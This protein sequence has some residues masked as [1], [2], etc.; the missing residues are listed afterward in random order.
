MFYLQLFIPATLV[1][2]LFGIGHL[3][4]EADYSGVYFKEAPTEGLA[5]ETGDSVVDEEELTVELDENG[6]PLLADKYNYLKI[7]NVFQGRLNDTQELF[8]LE[9]AVAT[10]QMNITADFFIKGIYE[11]ETNMVSEIS[12]LILDTTS[13]ELTT[14]VGRKSITDKI[15]NGLNDYLVGE[16]FSPD[17][18]YVYI[19][20]YNI[21]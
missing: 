4:V 11:I 18:H 17:I 2:L 3:Y 16:G 10:Y 5:T 12:T 19:I 8:S 9:I 6:L 7:E 1:F 14:L 20:N 13:E 21:I 15:M